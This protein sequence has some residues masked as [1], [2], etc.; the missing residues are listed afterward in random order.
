M[1]GLELS[2]CFY[3]EYGKKL[4]TENFPELK[5]A[6]GAVG[7]GSEFMGFDDDISKDHDYMAGFCIWLTKEEEQKYGFKLSR[8]YSSLPKEF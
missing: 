2:E 8:A 7:Q 3:N 5:Y 6:A 4:I 1:Q